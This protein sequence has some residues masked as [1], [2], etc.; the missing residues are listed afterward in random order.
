MKLCGA[1]PI[2]DDAIATAWHVTN[3]PDAMKEGYF[4]AID[5]AQHFLPISGIIAGSEEADA[6]IIRVKG[7]KLQPLALNDAVE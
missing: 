2:A 1:Y 5:N 7:Y 4:V 6:I 3:P